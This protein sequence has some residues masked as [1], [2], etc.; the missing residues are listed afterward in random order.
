MLFEIGGIHLG[1]VHF[2]EMG[3]IL[4]YAISAIQ[5]FETGALH[6]HKSGFCSC[7]RWLL[8]SCMKM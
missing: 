2:C 8:F 1:G 4:L 6:L 5:L 7:M 3:A